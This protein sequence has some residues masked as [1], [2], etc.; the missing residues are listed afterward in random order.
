MALAHTTL[1]HH[2]YLLYS[3]WSWRRSKTQITIPMPVAHWW[4]CLTIANCIP[5]SIPLC[6]ERFVT[7]G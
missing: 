4:W 1:I 2:A 5:Y 7:R 3:L 6:R